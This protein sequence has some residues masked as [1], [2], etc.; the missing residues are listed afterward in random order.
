MA[1]KGAPYGNNNAVGPHSGFGN[2]SYRQAVKTGA[3]LGSVVGGL[4]GLP[5][6]GLPGYAAGSVAG[7]ALGAAEGAGVHTMKKIKVGVTN[8]VR[9]RYGR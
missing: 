2:N 4:V 6:G 9:S 5:L 7:A 3:A 8:K 1:K